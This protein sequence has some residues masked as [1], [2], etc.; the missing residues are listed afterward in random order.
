MDDMFE[1]IIDVF[2][3]RVM[4][5]QVGNYVYQTCTLNPN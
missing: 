1:E 2:V 4:I 3:S 5:T